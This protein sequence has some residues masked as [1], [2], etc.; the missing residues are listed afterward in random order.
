MTA[1][2]LTSKEFYTALDQNKLIGSRCGNCGHVN[3]PQRQI[4]PKCHSDQQEII[5]F[6]GK[7]TLSAF[8][9]VSVPPTHM[10][11]A[12]YDAKNPYCVGIVT[13]EEGAKVCAQILDVDV[14]APQTIRVG[15]PLVMT[16]IERGEGENKKKYLAF[17]PV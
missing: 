4:C 15:T 6:N 16:M 5:E 12:G 7:G 2:Q 10:A 17:E 14:H 3:A 11:A 9:V 13:L 1:F 8:T